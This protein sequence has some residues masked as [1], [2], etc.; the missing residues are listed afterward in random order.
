MKRKPTFRSGHRVALWSFFL[1]LFVTS[2]TGC[3][4]PAAE[5]QAESPRPVVA[6]KLTTS[7]PT[8]ALRLTGTVDAWAEKDIAFEV[9]GQVRYIARPGTFLEGR[10][11][12]TGEVIIEGG[13]LGAVDRES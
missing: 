11:E 12:E 10:W 9:A 8:A 3:E 7:D 2:L 4:K 13:L 1:L 5:A 6:M